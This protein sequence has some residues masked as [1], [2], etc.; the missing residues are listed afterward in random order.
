MNLK[1]FTLTTL[2]LFFIGNTSAQTVI[3]SPADDISNMT[4][5]V[6][7]ISNRQT[8]TLN[9]EAIH[10]FTPGNDYGFRVLLDFQSETRNVTYFRLGYTFAVL[11]PDGTIDHSEPFMGVTAPVIIPPVKRNIINNYRPIGLYPY[12]I[13][14]TVPLFPQNYRVTIT[15]YRYQNLQ[16][17]LEGNENYTEGSSTQY[18]LKPFSGSTSA[19]R[20]AT[21]TTYPNPSTNYVSIEYTPTASSTIPSKQNPIQVNIFTKQ[22]IKVKS[23]N[24]I[25]SSTKNGNAL[26]T[27]N[28]SQL[29][30]GMYFFEIING[31]NTQI[32]TVIKE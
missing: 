6:E 18:T 22:G 21:V 10:H 28:T 31:K 23:Y 14:N 5:L 27:I 15:L 24:A 29:P 2:F 26:Y 30:K 32:K 25:N 13:H 8:F 7:D 19:G 9:T 20:S 11:K 3:Q 16:D 1:I 17:Y 12:F 4:L